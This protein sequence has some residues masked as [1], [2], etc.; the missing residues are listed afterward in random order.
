MFGACRA[1]PWVGGLMLWDW[2]A[3]LYRREDAAS[4]DDY[5]PFGKPAG[6][7]LRE[8]YSAWRAEALR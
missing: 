3:T 5:C 1:R 6:A 7:Y 2:P 4:N 8:Q